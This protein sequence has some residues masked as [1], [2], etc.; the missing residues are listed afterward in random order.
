MLRSVFGKVVHDQWRIVLGWAAFAAIWPAMYVALYPSIGALGEMQRML[1]QFPP[2]LREFFASSSLNLGTP[3]GFLNMELFTFVAPLLVLAYT[4]VVC[5]GATAG[6]EERGTM[7]LLLANPIPRWRIVVEKSA[8]FVIGTIVI[9]I[10]M[11]IGAAIGASA[12]EIDLDL[13]LVGQAI[14]SSCL[15]GFAL[16][17]LALALG[18]LTGRRWLAAG[19]SLMVVIAGF[20]LN[21]LGA[22]VDWLEPWRPLSPFYHY[23][24]ND[25]LSNGLDA[26]HALVLVAWAVI[27]GAIAVLAFER[28]DLAR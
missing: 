25:P 28:R 21:G 11:L 26:G 16:G 22:L 7:D 3:E 20:F 13:W 17:G 9:G 27:G 15:L 8:A 1:E 10:G 24:A 4:V 2:G 19:A 5:G 18:A 14:A 23:I 12:V 6:E